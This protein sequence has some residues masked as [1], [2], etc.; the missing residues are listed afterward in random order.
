MTPRRSVLVGLIFV[1]IAAV[2]WLLPYLDGFPVDPAGITMLLALGV[3]MSMMTF[4][5]FAGLRR[6]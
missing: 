5:L 1:V 2:Y 6:S 3:A 4:V